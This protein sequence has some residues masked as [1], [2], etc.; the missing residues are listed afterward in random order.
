MA[1]KKG[2]G[3]DNKEEET[4]EP[5]VVKTKEELEK[6]RIEAEVNNDERYFTLHIS[7]K[8]EENEEENEEDPFSI[9]PIIEKIEEKNK[10]CI[11]IAI[12][13]QR[14]CKTTK[15]TSTGCI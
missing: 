11:V 14:L 9:E 1:S 10:L 13:C 7:K 5:K 6:E 8:K 3:G 12:C 4:K 2:K 15:N